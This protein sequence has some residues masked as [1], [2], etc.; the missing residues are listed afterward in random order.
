[1]ENDDEECFKWCITRA[2][3]P[4]E[5]HSGRITKA[6]REQ[7]EK[8][9]WSGIEFPVAADA[10][11]INK[12]ERNN[13][14]SVTVFGY[15]KV[16]FPIYLFKLQDDIKPVVDLL[17]IANYINKKH[18]CWIKNFNRLMAARTEKSCNSMHYCNRLQR[19]KSS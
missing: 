19:C 2:L 18:Y 5:R 9:N 8:L 12:F 1:L 16:I 7:A 13:A 15:E 11:I 10:N 14:I 3:N 17:L 6:L 4:V